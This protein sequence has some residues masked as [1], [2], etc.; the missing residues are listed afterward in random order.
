MVS[1][2]VPIYN[3]QDFIARCARSLLSQTFRDIEYIFVDDASPDSSVQILMNTLE[4]FPERKSQVRILHHE[5]NKGLPAARN[6]GLIKA[7]GDYVYH[8]DSDDFL[9]NNMIE[10]MY[11]AAVQ[12]E[13]DFVWCDWYLSYNKQE[14]Y[15]SQSSIEEVRLVL[16]SM[17]IGTLKYN[18]WNKL[19]KRSIY[20]E[21]QI[22]FPEGH[23]MGEDMTMLRLL[24]C[25]RSVAY[26]NKPL[27]HYVRSN[28][29]AMTQHYS[30]KHLDDIR[31]NAWQTIDFLTVKRVVTNEELSYFKLNIKHPLLISDSWSSYKLWTSWYP[32][33][34]KY[35]FKNKTL[36]LRTRC[37][38]FLASKKLYVFVWIYYK[39][40]YRVL[41]P[42]IYSN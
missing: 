11:M 34:T 35:I 21:N 41:Y 7:R 14:R 1:I 24:S 32:E 12:S 20:L 27:Y 25:S 16:K 38:Q 33:A 36:P 31:F 15:M 26:V 37:I 17:L 8:C 23:S 30:Q 18:V 13:A 29:D 42:L 28:I 5:V 2:I 6:T 22:V 40:V 3:V 39:L 10:L 9:E 19:V 4:E